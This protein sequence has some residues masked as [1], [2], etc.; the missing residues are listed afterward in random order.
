[1]NWRG[2]K[3]LEIVD[4]EDMKNKREIARVL[5]GFIRDYEDGG[6]N[7]DGIINELNQLVVRNVPNS[8]CN[9]R[10]N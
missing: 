7:A 6:H 2:F 1:M 3:D 8:Y 5:G 10:N 4:P 9:N